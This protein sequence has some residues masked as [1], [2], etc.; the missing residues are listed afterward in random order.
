MYVCF[1]GSIAGMCRENFSSSY[2]CKSVKDIKVIFGEDSAYKLLYHYLTPNSY[3][4][5]T[6]ILF[7]HFFKQNKLVNLFQSKMFSFKIVDLW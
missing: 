5:V 3:S 4:M 2:S 7:V 6:N 1:D